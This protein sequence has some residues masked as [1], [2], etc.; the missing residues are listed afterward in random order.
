MKQ[1]E[2]SG[3]SVDEAV[4]HG[5]Q[6]LELSIDEVM[7]EMLQSES[8]GLFGIGAKLA[9]VRLTQR[10]PNDRFDTS[11]ALSDEYPPEMYYD[12]HAPSHGHNDR[13]DR[14]QQRDLGRGRTD[15]ND[16]NDRPGPGRNDRNDRPQQRDLSR[17]RND[18]NDRNDHTDRGDRRPRDYAP[19]AAPQ[20]DYQEALAREH[21][22]GQFLSG[23]LSQMGIEANVLAVATEDGLRLRIDSDTR[24][25]LIGR[26]GETLDALQYLTS[27]HVNR[28][29][30]QDKYVRITLDTEDYRNKR[31]DT[32]TRL[33]RRQAA[34]VKASGR[35]LSM[36]P[37]NPYER[38]ILHASLQSNPYVNTHSEGE[39]PNRRVVIT[40][41]R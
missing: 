11:P 9:R 12:T 7:I 3:R 15:R 8:K 29:L 17:D 2:F 25:L 31:E 28:T 27:L 37:M 35:P 39:E 19:P 26:R 33:A 16:R 13:N 6:E 34:R 1:G 10:E 5:L 38:R 36:E 14:P 41:K 30:K 23:L 4:F 18:R 24:G 32:L 21:P 22:A 40:P 20:Y